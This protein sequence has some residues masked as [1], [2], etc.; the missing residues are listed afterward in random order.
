MYSINSG[1]GWKYSAPR[2]RKALNL[3]CTAASSSRLPGMIARMRVAARS[4]GLLL[5]TVGNLP[6]ATPGAQLAPDLRRVDGHRITRTPISSSLGNQD[7]P[8]LRTSRR[9]RA[10]PVHPTARPVQV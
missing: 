3:A 10:A 9:A 7:G 6:F 2:A 5:L 8:A 1:A 4:Q